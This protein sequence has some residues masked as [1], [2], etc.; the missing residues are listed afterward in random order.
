MTALPP[1]VEEI[2][3]T[4]KVKHLLPTEWKLMDGWADEKANLRDI[5]SHVSGLPRYVQPALGS[6]FKPYS[7]L[8]QT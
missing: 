2:T 4:T 8:S 7:D 6:I 3:W 5:L 1:G